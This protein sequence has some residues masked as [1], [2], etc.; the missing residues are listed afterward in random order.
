LGFIL[1]EFKVYGRMIGLLRVEELEV[2]LN[3][4]IQFES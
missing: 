2:L 4:N 1:F 3:K